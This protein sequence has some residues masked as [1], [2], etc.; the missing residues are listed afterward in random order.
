MEKKKYISPE[1]MVYGM[2]SEMTLL[3]LSLDKDTG[4][5]G[6]AEAPVLMDGLEEY[7]DSEYDHEGEW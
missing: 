7:E 1:T 2:E 4:G 5:T 6:I 3:V